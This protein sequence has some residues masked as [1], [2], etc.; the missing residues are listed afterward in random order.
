MEDATLFSDH[1]RPKKWIAHYLWNIS[2]TTH[3][4]IKSLSTVRRYRNKSL[5]SKS[6]KMSN[7]AFLGRNLC[8]MS[9][10]TVKTSGVN[11]YFKTKFPIKEKYI[12]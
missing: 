2:G 8:I 4:F 6:T 1:F 5:R 11:N 7:C 9:K 12:L 10:Y 3:T